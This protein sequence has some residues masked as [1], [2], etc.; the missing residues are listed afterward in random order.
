MI[1]GILITVTIA[2]MAWQPKAAALSE[3]HYDLY[4][5][6]TTTTYFSGVVNQNR[7]RVLYPAFGFKVLPYL[8]VNTSGD[9]TNSGSVRYADNYVSPTAGLLLKPWSFLGLFAEYRRLYRTDT[10]IGR[11]PKE[12]DD[13]RYGAYAYF[14]K[15][16]PVPSIPHVEVYGES[17]A[18]GRYSSQP[19]STAWLKLGK[20]LSLS[21]SWSATPYLEAFLRESPDLLIGVD[22]RSLRFGGKLKWQHGGW[23]AQLLAYRRFQSSSVPNGWEALLVLS[24]DGGAQEWN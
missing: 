23:A 21:P 20:E 10:N 11:L 12:E 13:P 8:G 16:L 17:V 14:S 6:T 9:Y 15:P 4:S 1:S 22:E 24:A 2:A 7:L 5:E 18:L 19:V 3:L